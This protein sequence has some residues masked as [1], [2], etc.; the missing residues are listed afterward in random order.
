MG[1]ES[2]G[3]LHLERI[4]VIKRGE[5]GLEDTEEQNT[6]IPGLLVLRVLV[7]GEAFT[8]PVQARRVDVDDVFRIQPANDGELSPTDHQACRERLPKRDGMIAGV[9]DRLEI[10]RERLQDSDASSCT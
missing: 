1:Q 8:D 6:L 10:Q 7:S 5:K 3:D 4:L 9:G 2:R